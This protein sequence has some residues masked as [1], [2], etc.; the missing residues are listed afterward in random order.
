MTTNTTFGQIIA[1]SKPVLV[2]FFAEWCGHCKQFKKQSWG[3]LI[4]TYSNSSMLC[5]IKRGE[6]GRQIF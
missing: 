5:G 6:S 4:E 2:D 1:G 3:K